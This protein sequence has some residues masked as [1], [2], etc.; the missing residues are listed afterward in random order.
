MFL[1][2]V[3]GKKQKKHSQKIKR[4]A[5]PLPGPGS[6]YSGIDAFVVNCVLYSIVCHFRKIKVI[7]ISDHRSSR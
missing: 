5:G 1:Y 2:I 7:T 3:P 6:L 4:G